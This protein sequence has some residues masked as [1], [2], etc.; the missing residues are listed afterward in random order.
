MTRETKVGLIVGLAFIVVFAVI[1]SHK[2]TQ[3]RAA[4]TSDLGPIVDA[5]TE[6]GGTA[7]DRDTGRRPRQDA[8]SR[9]DGR[10]T[11]SVGSLAGR[12]AGST[13]I[14]VHAQRTHVPEGAVG[15]T[16]DVTARKGRGPQPSAS[17]GAGPDSSPKGNVESRIEAWLSDSGKTAAGDDQSNSTGKRTAPPVMDPRGTPGGSDTAPPA[18]GTEERAAPSGGTGESGA[19]PKPRIRQEHIVKKNETLTGIAKIAYG[20]STP[21]EINAILEANKKQVPSATGLRVGTKLVIPELSADQFD[22]VTFPPSGRRSDPGAVTA[23][24]ADG[25]KKGAPPVRGN[26]PGV[27]L[28]GG[29]LVT[30][31]DDKEL[32]GVARG[33][34]AVD[35]PGAKSGS[36]ESKAVKGAKPAGPDAQQGEFRWYTVGANETLAGIARKK[37]GSAKR[38]KEIADLNRGKYADPTRIPT[39]AKIRLPANGGGSANLGGLSKL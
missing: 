6:P 8:G 36:K 28:E 12:A 27:P 10:I 32:S 37:L 24:S 2:G 33:T 39:G 16:W 38:W 7:T 1:L 34:V 20:R 31:P 29:E 26:G 4:G 19:E 13:V 5:G 25:E 18:G 21:R 23:G 9:S 11:G 14:D 3:P 17:P 15:A 22:S 35:P 30:S